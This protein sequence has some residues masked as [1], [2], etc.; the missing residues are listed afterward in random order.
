[1]AQLSRGLMAR[2]QR[3]RRRTLATQG[4][5]TACGRPPAPGRKKC[6]RCLAYHRQWWRDTYGLPGK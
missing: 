1:M 3:N 4:K 6:E 2:Y 5:C